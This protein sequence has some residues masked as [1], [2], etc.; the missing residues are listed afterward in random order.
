[1]MLTSHSDEETVMASIMAGASGYLLKNT[2]VDRLLRAVRT[3]ASG[4]AILDHA[5]TRGVLDRFKSMTTPDE[6]SAS[7]PPPGRGNLSKR[8]S[9]VS[10]LIVE[11]FT[12]RE[13]GCISARYGAQSCESNT[14]QAGAESAWSGDGRR[15]SALLGLVLE[16]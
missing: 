13:M 8:V 1:M 9:E 2:N 3:V 6:V 14:A 4:G 7:D 15:L 16:A 12:N 10:L 11:E 5:I